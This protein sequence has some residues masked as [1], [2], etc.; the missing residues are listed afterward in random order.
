MV[1]PPDDKFDEAGNWIGRCGECATSHD[2][3]PPNTM[4][5]RSRC[6]TARAEALGDPGLLAQVDQ[7]NAH[8]DFTR[9]RRFARLTY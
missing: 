8:L 1:W 3:Y 6:L 4:G 5:G 2:G 7:M 9:S